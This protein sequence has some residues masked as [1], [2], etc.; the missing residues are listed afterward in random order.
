MSASGRSR[1]DE[2]FADGAAIDRAMQRAVRQALED[3]KRAGLPIV[4]WQDGQIKWLQPHEIPV[5][6]EPAGSS[7]QAD[8]SPT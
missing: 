5:A 6:A 3:H 7:K 2:L 4:V 8:Y 1:V